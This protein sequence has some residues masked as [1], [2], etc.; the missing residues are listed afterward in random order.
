MIGY[1]KGKIISFDETSVIIETGGVGYEVACSNSVYQ[2]LVNN[3]EGEAYIYTAVKEDGIFLYG[4]NSIE[5]KKIFLQLISVSGVGPKMGITVLSSMSIAELTLAIATSNVKALS[6]IKGLGKKTAERIILELKE[7]VAG[8]FDS[9]TGE[10][11]VAPVK[12]ANQDAV[13]AL[14][15]LGFSKAESEKAVISAEQ[16]GATSIEDIIAYA[17][18]NIK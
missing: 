12:K 5:E 11:S 13:I 1:L 3:G 7:K 14:A 16:S 15:S 8:D 9:S 10:I 4:F 2:K 17:L 6:S 18:K